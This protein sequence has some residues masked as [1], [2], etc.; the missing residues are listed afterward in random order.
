ML[1]K[2]KYEEQDESP[3]KAMGYRAIVAYHQLGIQRCMGF[4]DPDGCKCMLVPRK[5]PVR[6]QADPS[7]PILR[8]RGTCFG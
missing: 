2:S 3:I 6:R 1:I 4:L 5:D 8:D 7:P